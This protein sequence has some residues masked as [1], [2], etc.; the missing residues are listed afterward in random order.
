MTTFQ[1]PYGAL[2][3]VTLSMG[4]TNSVPIF[5]DNVTEIL[6]Q[7]IPEYTRPYIDNVPVR[8]PASQ[9]EMSPG[10]YETIPENNG[11]QRFVWEHMKNV[12]RIL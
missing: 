2:Q 6:K 1:T 3:L 9:Y 12:N 4:W 8:E 11:I 5:H 7:E 10:N